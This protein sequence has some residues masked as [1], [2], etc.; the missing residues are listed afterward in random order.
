MEMHKQSPRSEKQELSGLSAGVIVA[1]R[2]DHASAAYVPDAG[3]PAG[4]EVALGL[5]RKARVFV[6]HRIF[7]S[8]RL[9]CWSG[10]QVTYQ[11]RGLRTRR[12]QEVRRGTATTDL[13]AMSQQSENTKPKTPSQD[14]K[15]VTER[16]Q[17]H[18]A[19]TRYKRGDSPTCQA[20]LCRQQNKTNQD[21]K[22]NVMERGRLLPG[23][24][25]IKVHQTVRWPEI[26]P[27]A[28]SNSVCVREQPKKGQR[29][30][31]LAS[32][33]GTELEYHLLRTRKVQ[34]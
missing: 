26:C 32:Q 16:H 1:F 29:E 2:C 19:S 25:R 17:M 9:K 12:V 23:Q 28:F 21:Q 8:C 11:T 14:V 24:C 31:S 7:V 22:K 18:L 6:H 3:V 30:L 13:M 34:T 4:G 5:P 33:S 20:L 10:S 27:S 15:S